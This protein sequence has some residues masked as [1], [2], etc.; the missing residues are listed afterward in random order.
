MSANTILEPIHFVVMI[1]MVKFRSQTLWDPLDHR[2]G[3]SQVLGGENPPWI[4]GKQGVC[5][6]LPPPLKVFWA[7][8]EPGQTE[9][10]GNSTRILTF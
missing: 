7:W 5:F 8:P 4:G 10:A 9:S 1:I 6:S 2:A 3:L